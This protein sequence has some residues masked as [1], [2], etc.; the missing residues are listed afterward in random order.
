MPRSRPLMLLIC[1]QDVR[2]W[3]SS[4]ARRLSLWKPTPQM[5]SAG[6]SHSPPI[7]PMSPSDPAL[8]GS[9]SSLRSPYPSQPAAQWCPPSVGRAPV[10]APPTA[11]L[12][13]ST[14]HQRWWIP[15]TSSESPMPCP[16]RWPCSLRRSMVQ[17]CPD[18]CSVRSST[19]SAMTPP[20]VSKFLPLPMTP[21]LLP[22]LARHSSQ[23]SMAPRSTWRPHSPANSPTHSNA[24][25]L[26]SPPRPTVPSSCSWTHPTPEMPGTS[27]YSHPVRASSSF[28]LRW[29][30]STPATSGANSKAT[31]F[32]SNDSSRHCSDPAVCAGARSC[33]AR[34]RLGSS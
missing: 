4:P 27:R 32:D 15:N 34:S 13:P 33:S 20:N 10:V 9:R 3:R 22:M 1:G 11:P 25:P 14:G 5:F 18:R 24:G 29:H 6:C 8:A 17:P 31:C 2:P 7:H 19:S 12:S 16:E 21:D 26:R 23:G 30:S 28:P